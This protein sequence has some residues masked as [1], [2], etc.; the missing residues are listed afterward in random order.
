MENNTG[1]FLPGA[2]HTNT[3]KSHLRAPRTGA[4]METCSRPRLKGGGQLAA[5]AGKRP[6]VQQPAPCCTRQG[7]ESRNPFKLCYVD[8][9][10]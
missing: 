7:P 5:G 10:R 4:G 3:P 2:R 1:E 8:R 6:R 9:K